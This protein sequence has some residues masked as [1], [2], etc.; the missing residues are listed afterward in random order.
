WAKARSRSAALRMSP[1]TKGPQRTNCACPCDRLSNATGRKP[2]LANALQVWLPMKPA[3]PVT[4]TVS[5]RLH[6]ARLLGPQHGR[7][8][9]LPTPKRMS[10]RKLTVQHRAG[11]LSHLRH[12]RGAFGKE[13]QCLRQ[14]S[15]IPRLDHQPAIM[16]PNEPS[17][18][19]LARGDRNY[20]PPDR[21]N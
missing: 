19:A 14:R 13:D 20:R 15:S 10:A 9:L 12:P 3:P 17:D 1:W 4:R 5:I 21:S 8:Q 11:L 16:L 7:E 18:F 2:P 6:G